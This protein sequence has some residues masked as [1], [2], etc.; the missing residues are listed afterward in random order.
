M[1]A[2]FA[3]E[4][5]QKE[6]TPY[7]GVV[8]R[9]Q[10]TRWPSMNPRTNSTLLL[11]F[12]AILALVYPVAFNSRQAPSSPGTESNTLQ[13]AAHQKGESAATEGGVDATTKQEPPHDAKKVLS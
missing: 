7:P 11:P 2:S 3:P 12:I 9:L 4:H 13:H 5:W 1:L 10:A 6:L 8:S